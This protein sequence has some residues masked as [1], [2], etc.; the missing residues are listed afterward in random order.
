MG[1]SS[2]NILLGTGLLVLTPTDVVTAPLYGGTRLGTVQDFEIKIDRITYPITG[3][4]FA[5]EKVKLI[6]LTSTIT[7][8]ATFQN[9]DEDAVA[10]A[11]E[12]A[13]TNSGVPTVTFPETPGESSE[14]KLMFV[15]NKATT[16]PSCVIYAARPLEIMGPIRWSGFLPTELRAKWEL[17]RDNSSGKVFAMDLLSRLTV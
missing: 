9:W 11:F 5:G 7:L 1:A 4:E 6:T 17:T 14:H 10:A 2:N 8:E 13:S 16:Q 3:E 15:A 12:N